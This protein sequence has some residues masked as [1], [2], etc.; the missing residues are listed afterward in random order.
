VAV[1]LARED[2]V[3]AAIV[4]A[5]CGGAVFGALSAR[6]LDGHRERVRHKRTK[7]KRTKLVN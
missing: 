2:S 6:R 1:T 5:S 3:F 4:A 7:R